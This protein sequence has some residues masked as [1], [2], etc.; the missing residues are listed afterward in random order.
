MRLIRLL[1]ITLLLCF[2]WSPL[3]F[4]WSN[5]TLITYQLVAT[6]PQI[7]DGAPVTVESLESFLLANEAAMETFLAQQEQWMRD[8]LRHYDPRPV[9]LA[10]KATGKRQ[11]IRQRFAQAL[12]I[13]P[14]S[15]LTLYL[16]YL[17]GEQHNRPVLNISSVSTLS[18]P[19]GLQHGLL[20]ALSEGELVAPKD[21]VSTA[22]VEPDYGMDIGLFTD[23]NT[24]YGKQYGFG[25]QPFGNPNLEYGTQAPFHM[26][27]YHESKI[28]FSLARFLTQTYPEYRI[29]QYK[30]LAEFAF[31]RGH[32]YWGWRFMGWGLHY[33]GDFSNPYH[34]MPVPGNHTLKTLGVG[35]MNN[36]GFPK[37]QN[38]AIQ[39]AS[40]RHSVLEDFQNVVMT[41]AYEDKNLQH[42][43]IQALTHPKQVR[44]FEDHH[45]VTIISKHAH[46]RAH[47][48]H[49]ILE[50][51]MPEQYVNDPVVEYSTLNAKESLEETV[52]QTSGTG[53]SAKLVSTIADLLGGFSV[54]GASYV[55]DILKSAELSKSD[56]KITK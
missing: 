7:R 26:G 56:Q 3:A 14:N 8:N 10:F 16:Q 48:V 15:K 34:V 29:Q 42:P 25:K 36:L 43:A 12:R 32:D 33:L 40:N 52:E 41:K 46:D 18:D 19:D 13:N 49:D 28:I 30:Q 44:A 5:H 24:D 47:D 37:A 31:A 53:G 35:L 38:D 39:L 4:S 45:I 54:S 9:A 20:A 23:S 6:T 21:V 27:F 1:G 55:A 11:D 50:T 51:T 22:S 2:S 17:P